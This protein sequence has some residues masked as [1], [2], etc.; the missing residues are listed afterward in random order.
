MPDRVDALVFDLG[1]VVIDIDFERAFARWAEHAGCDPQFIGKRFSPDAAFQRH[2]R[3]E[4]AG[5]A[6]FAGLCN[7]LGIDLTHA[8]MLDGWN[9]IFVGEMPGMAELLAAAARRLPLYALTNSNRE[10]ELYWSREFAGILR[11]FREIYVS[12][13]IGSRKPD[14]EVYRHVVGAIGVPAERIVF[15]DDKFENIEGARACGLQ[16]VLVTS[17]ADVANALARVLP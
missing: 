15:F 2:E 12:S 5:E 9:A 3:G 6:Y 10:H 16:A 8:Q 13:T 11:H 17:I 7:S 4:I 1:R 14:A